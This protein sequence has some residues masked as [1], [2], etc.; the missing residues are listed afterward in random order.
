[1]PGSAR[2]RCW[3]ESGVSDSFGP[4]L[5]LVRAGRLP[6]GYAADDGAALHF[7]GR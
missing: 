3:F 2:A 6:A 1:L 4:R 7:I 5:A